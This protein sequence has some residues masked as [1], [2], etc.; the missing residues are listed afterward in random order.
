VLHDALA[1]KVT[2][3]FDLPADP[4]HVAADRNDLE[5]MVTNVLENAVRYVDHDG[6][7]WVKIE[8]SNGSTTLTVEDDGPGIPNSEKTKIFDRFYRGPGV[9][10]SGC[11]LGLAIV[12]DLALANEAT[13]DVSDREQGGTALH[14]KF[15][16]SADY[17]L[18]SARS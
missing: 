18:S 16:T 2:L 8:T 5:E 17:Q 9:K 12:K 4:I 3:D 1:K 10:G 14:L 11:G 13:I 15:R 7:V 6:Y